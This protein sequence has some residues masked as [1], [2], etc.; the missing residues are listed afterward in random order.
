MVEDKIALALKDISKIKEELKEIKKDMRSEEKI[1]NDQYIQLKSA[2]KDLRGQ[3]KDMED[4]WEEQ[5]KSDDFYN[6]L[7]EAR[8]RKEELLA[9]AQKDLFDAVAKLPV[10]PV[11]MKM[12]T[13][14]GP[15]N[16]QIHPEMKVFVN[17]KEEKK[18]PAA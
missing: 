8:L 15:V 18:G 16:V 1:E 14:I 3:L 11:Q 5:L 13:E 6:K 10:K 17:G 9:H 7:R 4:D 2:Y 12:E